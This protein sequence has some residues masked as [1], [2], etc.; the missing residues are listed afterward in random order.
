MINVVMP[1][2][3]AVIFV[4]FR[5]NSGHIGRMSRC[6]FCGGEQ[7]LGQHFFAHRY[8]HRKLETIKVCEHC[9]NSARNVGFTLAEREPKL[10]P[11]ELATTP[12]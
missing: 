12:P 5:Q 3:M 7:R 2:R 4:T 11:E 8:S 1:A 10:G 9:E 6:A